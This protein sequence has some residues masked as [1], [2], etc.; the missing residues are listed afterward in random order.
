MQKPGTIPQSKIFSIIHYKTIVKMRYFKKNL[1]VFQ[2]PYPFN[3]RANLKNLVLFYS[4][5]HKEFENFFY[6]LRILMF[7]FK[8]CICAWLKIANCR[9]FNNFILQYA[10]MFDKE[11]IYSW[12]RHFILKILLHV[13]P[14]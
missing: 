5:E 6:R 7:S 2:L 3:I 10:A 8:T 9:C 12:N 14:M 11:I 13:S 1:E 4:L